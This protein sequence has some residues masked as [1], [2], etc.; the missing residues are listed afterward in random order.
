MDNVSSKFSEQLIGHCCGCVPI[1]TGTLIYAVLLLIDSFLSLTSFVSD[2]TRIMV[3][4]YT[5][6]TRVI[7]GFLGFIGIFLCLLGILGERDNSPI[8]IRMFYQF[9]IVRIVVVLCVLAIDVGVLWRC[10]SWRPAVS[11]RQDE[12]N[13]VMDMVA[14]SGLCDHTRRWYI[15]LGLLDLV[16]SSYWSSVTRWYLGVI[17]NCPSYLISLNHVKAPEFYSGYANLSLNEQY[18][19]QKGVHHFEKKAGKAFHHAEDEAAKTYH[20]AARSY[21]STV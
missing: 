4:G 17:E 18:K 12:Y 3:G 10:E 20:H 6:H 21:H 1:R 15:F 13:P 5:Y 19:F 2:D 16:L 7:V 14:Q 11:M 8:L 9:S